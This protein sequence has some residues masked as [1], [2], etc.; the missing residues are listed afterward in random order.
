MADLFNISAETQI[1]DSVS[2]LFSSSAGPVQKTNTE[3]IKRSGSEKKEQKTKKRKSPNTKNG[4]QEKEQQLDDEES[5]ESETKPTSKKTKTKHVDQEEDLEAKW[6]QNRNTKQPSKKTQKKDNQQSEEEEE[7]DDDIE[8]DSD[9]SDDEEIKL[10]TQEIDKAD[11][12]V[13]VGN[14]PKSTIVSKKTYKE[15]RDFWEKI[16]KVSSIRFRSI[17]FSKILPRK[18]AFLQQELHKSRQAVNAYVVFESPGDAR[19]AVGLNGNI[20]DDHHLRIDLVSHPS[21]QDNK[22]C[23]FVGNLDFDADEEP[24]WK[25]FESCGKVEYVRIVR[26]STT[27]IGKGFCY[28]QFEDPVSVTKAIQLN[29]KKMGGEKGRALRVSRSKNTRDS[30]R[31]KIGGLGSSRRNNSRK[32]HLTS[33]EKTTLGRAKAAV[34]KAARAEIDSALEGTRAQKGDYIPGIKQGGRKKKPRKTERS[35]NF[36]KLRKQHKA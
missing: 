34:G 27:N 26:D 6:V 17:A 8:D 20:F 15:F 1:D 32:I 14:V 12:T 24:L 9:D 10:P 21:K 29:G 25:Y 3:V 36:K 2:N 33:D 35:S 19:K 5:S 18:A 23:V 4:G 11:A 22:R 28:V 30:Q 7:D 16:G 13:F 31:S